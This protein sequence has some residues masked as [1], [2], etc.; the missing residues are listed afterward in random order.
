MHFGGIERES[1]D[2][3][4]EIVDKRDWVTLLNIL[5]QKVRKDIVIISDYWKA[6]HDLEDYLPELDL[7][8]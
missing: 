1:G 2:W 5:K 4:F 6:Y 7:Q 8:H 3:L